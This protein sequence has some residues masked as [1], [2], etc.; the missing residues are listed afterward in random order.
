MRDIII[1]LTVG[2]ETYTIHRDVRHE[3]PAA[4]HDALGTGSEQELQQHLDQCHVDDWYFGGQHEGPDEDGLSM[5]YADDGREVT[6]DWDGHRYIAQICGPT[7]SISEDRP[8]APVRVG[9]GHWDGQEIECPADLPEAV[10]DAL[11]R[12]LAKQ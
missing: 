6:V 9:D 5:A 3:H 8:E 11:E 12:E 4:V 1:T 2:E 10:Y 7:V